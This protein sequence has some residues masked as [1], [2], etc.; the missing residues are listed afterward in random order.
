MCT[1]IDAQRIDASLLIWAISVCA[2]ADF[3][4][5]SP[6][7]NQIKNVDPKS[8]SVILLVIHMAPG[9]LNMVELNSIEFL[10]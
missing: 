3:W 2:T 9:V 4:K 6:F 8:A 5:N 7:K 10:F 1:R